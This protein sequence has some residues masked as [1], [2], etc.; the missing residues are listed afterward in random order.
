FIGL[1]N[2][3]YINDVSQNSEDILN[4]SMSGVRQQSS[5]FHAVFRYLPGSRKGTFTQNSYFDFSSDLVGMTPSNYWYEIS[6]Q[7]E[8]KDTLDWTTAGVITGKSDTASSQKYTYHDSE[9]N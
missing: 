4:C 8:S 6:N 9:G 2:S 1:A 3:H 7:V 5:P